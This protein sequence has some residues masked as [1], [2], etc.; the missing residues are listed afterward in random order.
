MKQKN[1]KTFVLIGAV[2]LALFLFVPSAQAFEGRGGDRVT[3]GSDE[4]IED[5][6]YVG[7]DVFTLDGTVKGDVFVGGTRVII[8]GT[9][10]G[11]LFVGAQEVIINGTVTD[12]VR[13]AGYALELG[14]DAQIGDDVLAAGYSINANAGSQVGG[15]MLVGGFQARLAGNIAGNAQVGA[16]GL[17][18]AG[19]IGGNL[20]A[21]V[22]DEGSSPPPGFGPQDFVPDATVTVPNVPAG[23]TFGPE[24]LV[25]G[26]LNYTSSTE[27]FGVGDRVEGDIIRDEPILPEAETTE[28]NP[29]RLALT[30]AWGRVQRFVAIAVAG[31]LALWL[32][33]GTIKRLSN[34]L[35]NDPWPS[36]GFGAIG[37]F[38]FPI[39][40][41]VFAGVVLIIAIL[42]GLLQFGNLSGILLMISVLTFF[43]ALLLF[44]LILSLAT[45]VI[46]GNLIGQWVW[47]RIQPESDS[48]VL[49]MLIGIAVVVLLI[50]IPL[51]G[52][53]LNFLIM[54]FGL[55]TIWLLWRE[56]LDQKT[57]DIQA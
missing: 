17:E 7:A 6:L 1:T 56:N 11:D 47:D 35:K 38:G 9:V 4:V 14:R 49:P 2:L 51:L 43:T 54:L 19:T 22:A 44:V 13:I 5:D 15:D 18:V 28:I 55:G 8:N 23:L 21:E 20:D 25:E 29:A 45:K 36:M 3:I 31:L 24:A 33:P 10:E 40:M 37:Y 48:L 27:L 57:V 52:S 46:V 39:V 26:D 34:L 32:T 42:L 50:A 30:W 41:F 53:F 16:N 12:D